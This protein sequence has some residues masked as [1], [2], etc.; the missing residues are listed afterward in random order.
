MPDHQ[1]RPG[2]AASLAAATQFLTLIPI[3]NGHDHPLARCVVMFPVVGAA[4]GLVGGVF[5][6]VA[7]W[8]GLGPVLAAIVC[9]VAMLV[10]TRGLHE[11]G[12][13]DLADGLGA[14]ADRAGR[15]A[16]MRDSRIGAFGAMALVI[17]I[18]ARVATVADL[19]NDMAVL[20][21]LVVAAAL[22]R[23]SMVVAMAVMPAAREDGMA[24]AAGEPAFDQVLIAL[25]IGTVLALALLFPWA[26][27]AA[28]AGGGIAACL[29]GW[30]AM[31]VLG[32]KTGD[33]LGAMQQVSE[34]GV[35]AG[36]VAVT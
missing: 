19:P 3:G 2:L 35:L 12:L 27:I 23:A 24:E 32:G 8:L 5:Y 31:T 16:V 30:L 28:L 18:G 11:D 36:A 34:I 15:L 7:G 1:E 6:I 9:V 17:V 26:W 4:I 33:V 21:A 22:S 25:G 29:V 10:L 20:A 14:H 13:A